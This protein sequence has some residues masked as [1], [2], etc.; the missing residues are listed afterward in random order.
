MIGFRYPPPRTRFFSFFFLLT[1]SEDQIKEEKK[2]LIVAEDGRALIFPLI[3]H[4][5]VKLMFVFSRYISMP[6]NAI[7]R[8]IWPS[9][10][11]DRVIFGF[12]RF[13][14]WSSGQ[15]GRVCVAAINILM[16][17]ERVLL[18]ALLLFVMSSYFFFGGGGFFLF[19]KDHR[20]YY[21]SVF[22]VNQKINGPRP[23]TRSN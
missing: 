21:A 3:C 10:D 20:R 15:R 12:I 22:L 11:E 8:W 17:S 23:R 6:Y 7:W 19:W 18:R 9:G 4:R 2:R 1:P 5:F 14:Q 16:K 13:P